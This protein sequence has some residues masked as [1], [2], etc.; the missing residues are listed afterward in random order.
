MLCPRLCGVLRPCSVPPDK[1]PGACRMGRLPV[2][3]RAGLHYWEEPCISGINGS[4]AVF[5]SGCVL[6]CV[7]C[8]NYNISALGFGRE[9]SVPR[10]S[11]IFHGLA[12]QGAHNINLV[13][14]THF[15][16]AVL[17]ALEKPLPVPVV[18]NSGGYERVETLRRLK[19]K[20]QVYLPD[21][22][23]SDNTLAV[24]YS[25]AKDYF[26]IAKAAI[27]EMVR[28]TGP[29]IIEN[30][31]LIR[32][33]LIRHLVLPGQIENARGVIDWVSAAFPPKTVLFSLMSQYTPC[34][35]ADAFPELRRRVTGAE[36]RALEAYLLGCG[37]SEGYLQEPGAA[38][39]AFI[40]TFDLSGI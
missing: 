26:E 3:A 10:L 2:L 20:V 4:G 37:I 19:G 36:Y 29:Y 24:R 23:Y 39:G 33:V 11:E 13:N 16:D 7:Y 31:L 28:Q 25:S 32:G 12:S 14:P 5:F 34:G 27:L 40:P 8:Q 21:L 9:V 1:G 15:T 38:D 22:K 17:E 18:W 30:D 6:K 35:R